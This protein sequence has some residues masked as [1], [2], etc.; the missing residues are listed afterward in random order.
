MHWRIRGREFED[1]S[2]LSSWIKIEGSSWI[3]QIGG[4]ELSFN[5]YKHD[6]HFWKLYVTR[7]KLDGRAESEYTYG[8]RACRVAQVKYRASA[9]S[10]HSGVEKA[11]GELEWVRVEEV[12]PEI[13]AVVRGD[14]G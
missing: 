4:C 14:G 10:P 11:R 7:W 6:G 9:K 1:G 3:P 12:D 13:H 2:P 5:I 8:G